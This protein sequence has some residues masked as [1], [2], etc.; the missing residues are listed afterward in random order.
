M[1]VFVDQIRRSI[2]VRLSVNEVTSGGNMISKAVL[3]KERIGA[4]RI[5]AHKGV[6]LLPSQVF[7]RSQRSVVIEKRIVILAP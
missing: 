3:N 5:T 6:A 4:A 2:P 7:V 1:P